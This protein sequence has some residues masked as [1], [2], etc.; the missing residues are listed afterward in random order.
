MD[1]NKFQELSKICSNNSILV[2]NHI[3]IF[4]LFTPFEVICI[5]KVESLVIG[6]YV[7]VISVKMSPDYKLVYII[8]N[9]AFYHHYFT[10]ASKPVATQTGFN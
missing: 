1:K 2:I 7:T 4:R 6:Q 5:T 10:I 8:Q 3:G 9:K